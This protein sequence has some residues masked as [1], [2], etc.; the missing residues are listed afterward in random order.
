MKCINLLVWDLTFFLEDKDR[1]ANGLVYED[2]R[3]LCSSLSDKTIDHKKDH[4]I[5]PHDIYKM[6]IPGSVSEFSA[7]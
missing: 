3:R 1:T 5:D 7:I 4:Q 6:P 2:S